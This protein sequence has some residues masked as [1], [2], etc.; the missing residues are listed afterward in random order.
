MADS[1]LLS[2]NT[3]ENKLWKGIFALVR[4][5]ST[6]VIYGVLQEKIMRV[7][8]G[9]NKEYFKFSLFL[10]FCNRI[11][12]FVVSAVVLVARKRRWIRCSGL[13]SCL[14]SRSNIT[15]TTCRFPVQT[16]AKCA[17]MIPVMIWGTVIMQKKYKGM[18]YLIAFLVTLGCSIFILFSIIMVICYPAGID[19][20]PYSRGRENTIWGVS[21]M[22]GYLS[23]CFSAFVFASLMRLQLLVVIYLQTWF[24]ISQIWYC[25]CF[26]FSNLKKFFQPALVISGSTSM[27]SLSRTQ[28]P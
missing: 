17:K 15:T 26:L 5:M 11:T 16:L 12:T 23:V 21:L 14:I 25:S 13:Q 22:L 4:I 9:A 18:D 3:R 27:P 20:I 2:S 8:Y 7:P 19:V 24:I 1:L 28:N 10:V 6:L